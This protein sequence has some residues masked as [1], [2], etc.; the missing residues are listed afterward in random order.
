[1]TESTHNLFGTDKGGNFTVKE[2]FF[3]YLSYWPLFLIF[4]FFYLTAGIMYIRY[5]TPVYRSNTLIL[6]KGDQINGGA[7]TSQDLIRT[8]LEGGV[9]LNKLDNEIQLLTSSEQI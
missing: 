4:L 7:R 3:K 9:K 2:H 8:A 5:A 6:V 1:M